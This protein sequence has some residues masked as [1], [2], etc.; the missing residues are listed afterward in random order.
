MRFVI[1]DDVSVIMYI[2]L[3]LY[4]EESAHYHLISVTL[5]IEN[6]KFNVGKRFEKERKKLYRQCAYRNIA[7]ELNNCFIIVVS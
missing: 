3:W 5:R 1:G 6:T 4:G 7:H 2:C